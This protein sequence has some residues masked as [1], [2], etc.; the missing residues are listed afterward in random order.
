MDLTGKLSI[1]FLWGKTNQ[2]IAKEINDFVRDNV[3]FTATTQLLTGWRS[4]GYLERWS[5]YQNMPRYCRDLK[6]SL[7]IKQKHWQW[8]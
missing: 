6:Q 2:E 1:S 4:A 8:E 3:Q 7:T 5:I